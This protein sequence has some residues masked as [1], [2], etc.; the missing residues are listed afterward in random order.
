M[1][2]AIDHHEATA[3]IPPLAPLALINRPGRT[4]ESRSRVSVASVGGM[5]RRAGQ[6]EQRASP[7]VQRS[8]CS[9]RTAQMKDAK[10]PV[11]CPRCCLA[12]VDSGREGERHALIDVARHSHRKDSHG[13]SAPSGRGT[14]TRPASPRNHRIR[15]SLHA[16]MR[17][18]EEV[19]RAV[20]SAGSSLLNSH[21][22]VGVGAVTEHLPVPAVT[23]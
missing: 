10:L 15:S 6:L 20:L 5:G 18:R 11:F 17:I 14:L 9:N 23:C 13:H 8:G 4:A 7:D 2:D 22:R 1:S 16:T 19:G 12:G 21:V 3:S